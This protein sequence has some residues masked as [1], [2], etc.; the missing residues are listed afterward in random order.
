MWYTMGLMGKAPPAPLSGPVILRVDFVFPA[1]REHKAGTPK[2]TRPD[3]DNMVKL[4][5]DC[6]THAGFWEDDAQ[7]FDETVIKY[8]D[9]D[10][11]VKIYIR[12]LGE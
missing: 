5:K 7:V 6:L 2:T 11:G 8:Y 12:R 10:P 1:S 9:T 4:L 3:T